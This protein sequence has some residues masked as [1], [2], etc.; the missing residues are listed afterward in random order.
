MLLQCLICYAIFDDGIC[1]NANI[2]QRRAL[3]LDHPI[4][5]IRLRLIHDVNPSQLGEAQWCIRPT[6]LVKRYCKKHYWLR[7][8]V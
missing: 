6:D 5:F 4:V 1:L 3:Y 7:G 2:F 8:A